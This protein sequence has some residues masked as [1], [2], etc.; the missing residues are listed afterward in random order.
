MQQ[1]WSMC[2]T[3]QQLS[4]NGNDAKSMQHCNNNAT[5]REQCDDATT[6][7][8]C[9]NNVTTMQ[10]CNNSATLQQQCNPTTTMQLCNNNATLQQQCNPAT[11]NQPRCYK[12][13]LLKLWF[14]C[15]ISVLHR[16]VPD[17][18]G[19][20]GNKTGNQT[21]NTATVIDIKNKFIKVFELDDLFRRVLSDI[22]IC[23]KELL[24]L[25]GVAVGTFL[26]LGS[27]GLFM[28]VVCGTWLQTDLHTCLLIVISN[29]YCANV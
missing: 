12:N 2:D 27:Y 1:Q 15:S 18:L 26:L 8:P 24:A 22:Y 20:V 6:M 10:P 5:L 21:M 14:P 7:Q 28:C 19:L 3:T 4:N 23:W 25:C 9:D 17:L 13:V 11:T 29:F 16:C